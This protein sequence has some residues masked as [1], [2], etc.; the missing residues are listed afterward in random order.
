M[1]DKNK[2]NITGVTIKPIRFV[3]LSIISLLPEAN[4]Y[5]LL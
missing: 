4:I 1:V 2:K 5:F 3:L